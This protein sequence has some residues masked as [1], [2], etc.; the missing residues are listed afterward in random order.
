ME[1]FKG[2]GSILKEAMQNIDKKKKTTGPNY[3]EFRENM[4][5]L[6]NDRNM[7]LDEQSAYNLNKGK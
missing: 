7:F 6:F 1:S 4:R 3:L 5:K 2:I